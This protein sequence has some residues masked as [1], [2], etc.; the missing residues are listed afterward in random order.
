[1]ADISAPKNIFSPPTPKFPNSPQTPSRPPRPPPL[2]ETPGPGIIK[3]ATSP[4]PAPRTAP[5]SP[6]SRKIKNIPNVHQT[7]FSFARSP[8]FFEYFLFFPGMRLFC[9]QLEASYLQW[10]FL[11]PVDNFGFFTYNWSFFTYSLTFFTYSWSLFGLQWESAPNKHL[12][13]LQAETLNCKQTS[14][15][16]KKKASLTSQCSSGKELL[17]SYRWS[18]PLPTPRRTPLPFPLF[19]IKNR[20]TSGAPPPFPL[21]QQKEQKYRNVRQGIPIREREIVL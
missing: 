2:L 20:P 12:N 19:S 18:P 5:S 1:M 3:K 14:S 21:P 6:P 7:C 17:D 4:F 8:C 10:S 9:L 13:G 11:L 15:N 16:C